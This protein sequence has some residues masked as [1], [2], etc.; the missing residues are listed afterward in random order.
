MGKDDAHD[1]DWRAGVGQP[2]REETAA[3]ASVVDER[4]D[5]YGDSSLGMVPSMCMRE[6]CERAT[7]L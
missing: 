7:P 5:L 1:T 6:A 2:S 3:H 4:D